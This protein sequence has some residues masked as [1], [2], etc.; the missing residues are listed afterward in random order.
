MLQL[1]RISHCNDFYV[2]KEVKQNFKGRDNVVG[3]TTAYGLD[4]PGIESRW[5]AGFSAS[6]QTDPETHTA[7]CTIGAWSFLGVRCGRGVRLTPHPF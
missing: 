1:P 5:G 4:G 6:V 2:L 3:I 7:S